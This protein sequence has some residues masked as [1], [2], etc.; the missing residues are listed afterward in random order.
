MNFFMIYTSIFCFGVS[1]GLVLGHLLVNSEGN[2]RKK[3]WQAR[4]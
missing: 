3:D 2:R 1:A 4:L